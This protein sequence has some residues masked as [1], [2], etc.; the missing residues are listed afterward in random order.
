MLRLSEE[1][2]RGLD[3]CE[4]RAPSKMLCYI[5]EY[6]FKNNFSYRNVY[7]RHS[8]KPVCPFEPF[9]SPSVRETLSL[10]EE[11][12][13]NKVFSDSCCEENKLLVMTELP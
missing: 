10:R 9:N 7:A 1:I 12:E 5:H 3:L 8:Q 13:N 4:F 11:R 6:F 2:S